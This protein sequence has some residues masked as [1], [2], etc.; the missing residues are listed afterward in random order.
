MGRGGSCC[1]YH[2]RKEEVV[3][4]DG[5]DGNGNSFNNNDKSYD[6]KGGDKDKMTTKMTGTV[7]C[8]NQQLVCCKG[9][10]LESR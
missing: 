5:V 4:E 1:N 9:H 6:D 7:G 8:I 3:E 2:S 10:H